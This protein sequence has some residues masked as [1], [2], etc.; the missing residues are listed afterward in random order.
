MP[1]LIYNI[2]NS[3]YYDHNYKMNKLQ[4]GTS[5]RC[6][7]PIKGETNILVTAA[8]P[9]VNNE[10]HL[11]NLIGCVLSADIYA[12]AHRS[13]GHNV[14]FICGSDEYGTATENRARREGISF[15]E[16]CNKYHQLHQNIYN[17]FN[18]SFDHYGRTNTLKQ[19]EVTHHVYKKIWKQG[20]LEPKTNEQFYC[21]TCETFL[22]DRFITGT[23]PK[24]KV[25]KAKGDECDAC[26]Y[27]LLSPTELID[28]G[29]V[30]DDSNTHRIELRKTENLYLKLSNPS[31][32]KSILSHFGHVLSKASTA[33]VKAVT[34]SW[35]KNGLHDRCVTRDLKWGTPIPAFS[36]N[37]I[38]V[39]TTPVM[40]ADDYRVFHETYH[41]DQEEYFNKVFYVWADAVLGYISITYDYLK[42]N[43]YD[44]IGGEEWKVWWRPTLP[45]EYNVKLVQFIGKDNIPFHSIIFPGILK[46]LDDESYTLPTEINSTEYLMNPGNTKFSKSLKQGIFCSEVGNYPYPIDTWRC[47]LAFIRPTTKDSVFDLKAMQSFHNDILIANLGNFINRALNLSFRHKSSMFVEMNLD[48]S[49]NSSSELSTIWSNLQFEIQPLIDTIIEQYKKGEIREATHTLFAISS[50]GNGFVQYHKPWTLSKLIAA[51]ETTT[52]KQIALEKLELI[53]LLSI[54]IAYLLNALMEPLMP[55]TALTLSASLGLNYI[56]KLKDIST[57]QLWLNNHHIESKPVILF[58]PVKDE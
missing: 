48:H 29:C 22:A 54:N 30:A 45:S 53:L 39:Q 49:I 52:A 44:R 27:K 13:L 4:K 43:G 1:T 7:V 38:V 26:G 15:K 10:P 12:R 11:G 46:A 34:E 37:P 57:F 2:E 42:R 23:C 51:T 21:Q 6:V 19:T 9:Y 35:L 24:C 36:P 32:S 14:L 20:L 18:I 16:L 3:Q 8:L 33:N 5:K 55:N 40:L 31:L 56:P 47:Y 58:T 17:N 28:P 41:I 50:V 25:D